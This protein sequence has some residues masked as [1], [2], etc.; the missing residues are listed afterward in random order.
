[1][2]RQAEAEREW[3]AEAEAEK[4]RIKDAADLA[5]R[6]KA[7]MMSALDTERSKVKLQAEAAVNQIQEE[8]NAQLLAL[9]RARSMERRRWE[10]ELGAAEEERRLVEADAQERLGASRKSYMDMETRCRSPLT[11]TLTINLAL[12][13]RLD[14]G[15]LRGAQRHS[16]KK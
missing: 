15:G 7:S 5:A 16:K 8:S 6:E 14:A 12:I 3:R 13:W 4:Q 11:L 1:M 10:E 9:E 2:R